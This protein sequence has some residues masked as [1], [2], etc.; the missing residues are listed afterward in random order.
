MSPLNL[1][2]IP[3]PSSSSVIISKFPLIKFSS[4]YFFIPKEKLFILCFS[5]LTS[6]SNISLSSKSQCLLIE[7]IVGIPVV[8]VLVL[9]K[10]IVSIE[11]IFQVY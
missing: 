2:F 1:A 10:T 11:S 5:I 7:L 4:A 9:S 6:I 3:Y 8:I